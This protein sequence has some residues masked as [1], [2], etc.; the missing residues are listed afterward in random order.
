MRLAVL[1]QAAVG[2][3]EEDQEQVLALLEPLLEDKDDW[4]RLTAEAVKEPSNPYDVEAV[5]QASVAGKD[6]LQRL[7]RALEAAPESRGGLRPAEDKFMA[8]AAPVSEDTKHSHFVLRSS[9]AQEE[10]DGGDFHVTGTG[11]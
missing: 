1:R 6:L 8:G 2:K 10:D 3:A 7:E 9:L 5:L 11:L 4:P